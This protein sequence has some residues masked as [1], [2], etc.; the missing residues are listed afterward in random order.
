MISSATN[1]RTVITNILDLSKIEAGKMEVTVQEINATSL[2]S[3]IAETTRILVGK[4]PVAV[5]IEAPPLPVMVTTDAVKLRQVLM[6]LAS[7]AAKFT[8]QGSITLGLAIIGTGLEI[9]VADTGIGIKEQDLDK[10][11]TAFGR[12]RT[13]KPSSTKGQGSV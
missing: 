12:S 4:K 13:Q 9:S 8:E 7:N 5:K 3:E 2:I 6:N 11:F 10:L 1:L